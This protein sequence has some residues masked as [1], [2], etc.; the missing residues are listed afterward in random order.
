M[1]VDMEDTSTLP[2]QGSELTEEENEEIVAGLFNQLRG[3]AVGVSVSA[4]LGWEDVGDLISEGLLEQSSVMALIAETGVDTSTPS[5]ALMSLAQFSEVVN[6]LDDTLEA[7]ESGAIEASLSLP[8][9]SGAGIS[10]VDEDEDEDEEDQQQELNEE[11]LRQLAIE[12]FDELRATR[13]ACR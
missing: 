7:L 9:G 4:F 6:M 10:D 5:S 1:S 3:D 12:I 2:G 8:T 13:R 11:E